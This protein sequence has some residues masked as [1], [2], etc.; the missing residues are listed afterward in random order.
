MITH[1]NR[2]GAFGHGRSFAA[3]VLAVA[4]TL[5]ASTGAGAAG[6]EKT[7]RLPPRLPCRRS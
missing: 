5:F 4:L 6:Q 2:S 3:G 1:G 7:L